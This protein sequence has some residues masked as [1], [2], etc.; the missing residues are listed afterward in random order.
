MSVPFWTIL[1]TWWVFF[2]IDSM[3]L[4]SWLPAV[5]S[6]AKSTRV[7]CMGKIFY[8]K[9]L[10]FTQFQAYEIFDLDF[11]D[12]DLDLEYHCGLW[13]VQKVAPYSL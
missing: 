9:F 3:Q 1:G 4:V 6:E 12:F 11:F 8:S 13:Q 10:R 7:I 5:C 2:P